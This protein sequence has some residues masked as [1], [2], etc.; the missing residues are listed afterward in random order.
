M[1]RQ[2]LKDSNYH[3]PIKSIESQLQSKG[4]P[5]PVLRSINPDPITP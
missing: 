2:A 4:F 1:N 5:T 3:T